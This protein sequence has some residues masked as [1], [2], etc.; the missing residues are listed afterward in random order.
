MVT[1]DSL[2]YRHQEHRNNEAYWNLLYAALEGGDKITDAIKRELLPNPDG[3]PEAVIAERV[4]LATYVN[5]ISPILNRFTSELFSKPGIYTGS[6]D[7]WWKDTFFANGCLLDDDDDSRASFH[8]FLQ[9]ATRY[10]LSTGKAVAQIDTRIS[11]YPATKGTQQTLGELDPY[12]I[13]H[14]RSALW[15]WDSSLEGFKFVKL[16]QFRLIRENWDSLPIP[17]HT[18]TI[19]FRDNSRILTSKYRVRYKKTVKDPRLKPFINIVD[20][21]D[22]DIFTDLEA[23]EVFNVNGEYVF[24]IV[25]LTL[26]TSLWI[27][28]QL[29]E[30]QKSY[31][32]QTAAIDYALYTGNYGILTINN[33]EDE[34][35]DPLQNR[36]VG[37]GYYICLKE[38]QSMNWLERSG[39]SVA[40]ALNYRGELKRDI[41]DTLQQI[42]MSASDGA[43]ILSRSGESKKEDR[44]PEEILLTKYG[45]LVK[46]FSKNILDC[47]SIA[48]GE[49][50]KWE[51]GGFDDFISAGLTDILGDYAGLQTADIQSVTYKKEI[52]KA[53]IKE[54]FK[55]FDIDP[56][57]LQKALKEIDA[58]P[59]VDLSSQPSPTVN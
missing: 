11:E 16:Q 49:L 18:F 12:V 5:K 6:T 37:D 47:A 40:T 14:P 10:A 24:P 57:L 54:V 15:D 33:V 34:S 22:V 23:Q 26:P 42:A 27:G 46:E 38:G 1:L 2:K 36:S 51:I 44:R 4:K 50:S 59:N 55:A 35:E 52:Q 13:L 32:R 3:R 9:R 53:L 17:E 21:V 19:Y 41:Y 7:I 56:T 8:N 28:A 58:M 48:R 29:M 20:N 43:S 31:F 30:L 45:E 25:T 39:S